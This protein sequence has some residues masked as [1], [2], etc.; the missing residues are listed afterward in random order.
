MSQ[1][2]LPSVINQIAS[3]VANVANSVIHQPLVEPDVGEKFLVLISKDLAEDE[4]AAFSEFG[5]VGIWK[6]SFVN[7]PLAELQPCDYRIVDL[8]IK[9][10]RLQLGKEDLTKWN[11][12]HYVSWVQKIEQYIE[13]I[14]GN[15]LTSIPRQAA[16]KED[17]DRQ[18]MNPKIVS[19]SLIKS[20][21]RFFVG[22]FSK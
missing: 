7:I 15:V 14:P 11:V 16:N 2:P 22:C 13:Q 19:P 1:P 4:L 9:A 20:I 3:S 5:K 17:F 21:I 6:E 10:A 8:R 12:V 18:L